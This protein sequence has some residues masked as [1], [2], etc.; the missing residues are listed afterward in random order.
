MKALIAP[1]TLLRFL[2]TLQCLNQGFANPILPVCN[3]IAIAKTLGAVTPTLPLG[4]MES[5]CPD[6]DVSRDILL[7]PYQRATLGNNLVADYSSALV[8]RK[9]F[10]D[11]LARGYKIVWETYEV[12]MNS[13]NASN[14]QQSM[15]R[16]LEK[17]VLSWKANDFTVFAGQLIVTFGAL[18]L[19]FNHLPRDIEQARD[20]VSQ[21]A[22]G[23][24][25]YLT[26][27][28]DV[29]VIGTFHI[30]ATTYDKV[31]QIWLAVRRSEGQVP[32][33]GP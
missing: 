7:A 14:T 8:E 28:V 17:A 25:N 13:S 5:R 29:Y 21:F 19:R 15:Y 18:Q 1:I 12:F 4:Q 24:L 22:K 27:F 31:V 26:G 11:T 3:E 30:L 32:R 10:S 6:V 20:F 9:L 33:W 23:M 2:V 16:Q